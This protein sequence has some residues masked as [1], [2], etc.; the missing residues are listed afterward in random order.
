MSLMSSTWVLFRSPG[1]WDKLD[2]D[3]LLGK[4]DQLFKFIEKFRYLGMENLPQ[5]F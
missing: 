4:G 2:L 3:S 1:L 5:K